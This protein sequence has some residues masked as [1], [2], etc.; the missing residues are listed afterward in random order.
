MPMDATNATSRNYSMLHL[1]KLDTG[2]P[3]GALYKRGWLEL[4]G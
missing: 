1:V 2:Q 3:L 4:N